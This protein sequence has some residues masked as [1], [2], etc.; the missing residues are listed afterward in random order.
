M[1]V[2]GNQEARIWVSAVKAMVPQ[3]VCQIIDEAIQIHGATGISQWTPLARMYTSARTP[4]LADGPVEFHWDH[5][6]RAELSRNVDD[7]TSTDGRAAATELFGV[8]FSG[9]A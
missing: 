3:R 7:P 2:M 5:V 9:P 8:A 1:D 4:R 6:G